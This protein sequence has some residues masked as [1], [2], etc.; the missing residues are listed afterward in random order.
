MSRDDERRDPRVGR[1]RAALR[2]ALLELLAVT[3]FESITGAMIAT[4]AGIGYAT[5]FRHYADPRDLLMDTVAHLADELVEKMLPALLSSG[6][7]VAARA[8]VEAVN[9]ERSTYQA[10]LQGA[11]DATRGILVRHLSD[12]MADLPDLSPE[13]L[14]QRLAVRFAI[15]GT[16][17]LLDWW[18]REEPLLDLDRVADLVDRLVIAK[19]T[20][21]S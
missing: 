6:T 17:E 1:S 7:H 13:W 14:P 15:V 21:A 20:A 4:R 3:P 12:H 19:I 5:Y 9:A 11:G 10:L 18:L 2:R 8:L 16:I